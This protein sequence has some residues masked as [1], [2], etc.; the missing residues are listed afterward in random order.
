[1]NL[2]LPIFTAVYNVHLHRHYQLR[3][4]LLTAWL[5]HYKR[6]FTSS[7]I[8]SKDVII[9]ALVN[10]VIERNLAYDKIHST[11]AQSAAAAAAAAVYRQMVQ[12]VIAVQICV[13]C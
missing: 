6:G 3:D 9:H 10:K 5:H 8:A 1:M 4:S 2:K 11:T 13:Q 7:T 12:A